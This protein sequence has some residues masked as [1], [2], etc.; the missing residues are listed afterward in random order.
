MTH[1]SLLPYPPPQEESWPYLPQ[2]VLNF[3]RGPQRGASH[4]HRPGIQF[5][6]LPSVRHV[7]SDSGSLCLGPWEQYP[8]QMMPVVWMP[9]FWP[10][11]LL[12]KLLSWEREGCWLPFWVGN[13][14]SPSNSIPH[15]VT[16]AP[17]KTFVI[18]LGQVPNQNSHIFLQQY[19]TVLPPQ[20]SLNLVI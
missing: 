12:L 11:I 13:C 19:A 3:L 1:H 6:P 7:F 9:K 15:F 16:W 10:K 8:L 5:R 17:K 20:D 14:S 4:A 2:S 18:F